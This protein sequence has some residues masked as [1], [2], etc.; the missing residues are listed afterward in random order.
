MIKHLQE[1]DGCLVTAFA[2]VLEVE[3]HVVY[4]GVGAEV[5]DMVHIQVLA[6]YMLQLGHKPTLL[7]RYPCFHGMEPIDVPF[8]EYTK[9]R[10]VLCTATHAYAC[11]DGDI[12]NPSFKP[13]DKDAILY[14]IVW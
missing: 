3:P 12:W 11:E 9:A 13:V 6:R 8:F 5:G 4:E 1:G 10:S 7:E 2:C 14:G